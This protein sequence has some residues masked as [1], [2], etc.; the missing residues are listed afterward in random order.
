V[1]ID[2]KTGTPNP[3]SWGSDRPEE[4]QLPLYCLC[5]NQDIDAILF[6]QVNAKEIAYKG[7]GQLTQSLD[8]VIDCAKAGA[9]DLPTD[10]SDIQEHWRNCLEQLAQEFLQGDCSLEFKSPATKRFYQDLAPI[11]RW[12][13][14]EEIRQAFTTSTDS[15]AN[16]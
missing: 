1:L 12:Q 8:G 4:P 7:L 16:L 15:G 13:E 14:E 6:A 2:Y 10:W 3:K 11:M 5:Y 9:L